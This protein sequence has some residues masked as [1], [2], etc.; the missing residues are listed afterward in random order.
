MTEEFSKYKAGG[1][2]SE[3]NFM[4]IS[5]KAFCIPMFSAALFTIARLWE[6][7]KWAKTDE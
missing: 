6:Q 2:N 7:L 4:S 5:R 3:Q 1:Q